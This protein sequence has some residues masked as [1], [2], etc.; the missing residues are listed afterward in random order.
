LQFLNVLA[1][2][3]LAVA[4]GCRAERMATVSYRHY[5]ALYDAQGKPIDGAKRGVGFSLAEAKRTLEAMPDQPRRS[6][7]GNSRRPARGPRPPPTRRP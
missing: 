6:G 7:D 4:K 1:I 3:K 5:V 2:K